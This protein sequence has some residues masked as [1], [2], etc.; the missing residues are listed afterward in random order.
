M[1]HCRPPPCG[2]VMQ[3]QWVATTTAGSFG[4]TEQLHCSP[5][6]PLSALKHR[7]VSSTITAAPSC[8]PTSHTHGSMYKHNRGSTNVG[9]CGC[10]CV[11]RHLTSSTSCSRPSCCGIAAVSAVLQTV[12]F[13]LQ[14]SLHVV[15]RTLADLFQA[16]KSFHTAEQFCRQCHQLPLICPNPAPHLLRCNAALLL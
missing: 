1:T 6:R 15:S 12:S 4:A 8:M 14:H 5:G 3:V 16:I 10:A 7:L 9:T 13:C 2:T 11:S